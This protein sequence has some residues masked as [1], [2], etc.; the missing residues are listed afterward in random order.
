MSTITADLT[1]F[2]EALRSTLA[3]EA[4]R[5]V[6][7]VQVLDMYSEAGSA[8]YHDFTLADASEVPELVRAVRSTSGPVLELA[9]GSG[10]ITLPLLAIGRPV[11]AVDL[12]EPM[13]DLL[14]RRL[15]QAPQRLARACETVVADITE[16]ERPAQFGAI[17][18]GTTSLSLLDADQRARTFARC[19]TNTLPDGRLILTT[20]VLTGTDDERIVTVTGASGATYQVVDVPKPAE[21]SRWT[22]VIAQ[23]G[24]RPMALWSQI[25]LLSAEVLAEEVRQA[26]FE[27][28][29]Q[30]LIPG[31]RYSSVLLQASLRNAGRPRGE[32]S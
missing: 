10:R 15:E 7:D 17:V 3:E 30:Q 8:V 31:E 11:C 29:D 20:S 13:I 25:R 21:G 16:F 27:I 24:A 4:V 18:V 22:V 19:R 26:G 6:P 12:S 23:G 9:A 28:V 14:S 32:H 2:P 1:G 5:A